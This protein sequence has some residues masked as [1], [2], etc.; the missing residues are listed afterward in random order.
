M[1]EKEGW[2]T[3]DVIDTRTSHAVFE[4]WAYSRL[5]TSVGIDLNK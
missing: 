2:F 1:A 4:A 5:A 3:E